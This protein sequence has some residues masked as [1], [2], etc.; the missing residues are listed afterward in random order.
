MCKVTPVILHGV[1]SRWFSVMRMYL[2]GDVSGYEPP[3][4]GG[5]RPFH[6]KST[7]LT[8]STSGH[9]VVQIWS[10]NTPN[11]GPNESF[12]AHRVMI[13]R[14][15]ICEQDFP[16][17]SHHTSLQGRQ[18]RTVLV[19]TPSTSGA[20]GLLLVL[21]VARG[22]DVKGSFRFSRLADLYQKGL[23]ARPPESIY[24]NV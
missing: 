22:A 19:P 18:R 17:H 16:R 24:L 23:A 5:A 8:Q 14:S 9:C 21:A 20:G 12:V 1:V 6:H 11:F 7:C 2:P 10:R 13:Q 4:H 3:P 15:G